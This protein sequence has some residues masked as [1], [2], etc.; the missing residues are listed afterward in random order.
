MKPEG[1]V[2]LEERRGFLYRGCLDLGC[3][4]LTYHIKYYIGCLMGCSGTNKKTNYSI[5]Q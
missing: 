5:R 3:K 4:V 1:V 2:W